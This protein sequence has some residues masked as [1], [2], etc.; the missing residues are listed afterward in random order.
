VT[1]PVRSERLDL[2]EVDG[3]IVGA[4]VLDGKLA[5]RADDLA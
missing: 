2:G 4:L 1:V 3:D 5:G